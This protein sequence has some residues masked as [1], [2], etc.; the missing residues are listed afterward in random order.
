MD[1]I[2]TRLSN[3]HSMGYGAM[4]PS[5]PN[6][7]LKK[8]I[9]LAESGNPIITPYILLLMIILMLTRSTSNVY[10]IACQV[11][12]TKEIIS[13]FSAS[14]RGLSLTSSIVVS[15]LLLAPLVQP[16]IGLLA[17]ISAQLTRLLV[18]S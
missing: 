7:K 6:H 17:L 8:W 5:H 11:Y 13:A 15:M 2:D 3:P 10:A 14:Q 1:M 16:S 9:D 18:Y 4:N 12:F